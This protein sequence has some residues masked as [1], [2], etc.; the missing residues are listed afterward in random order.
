[1]N[2][3]FLFVMLPVFIIATELRGAGASETMDSL[4]GK[5]KLLEIA[6]D[7][8]SHKVT[9]KSTEYFELEFKGNK[10]TASFIHNATEEGTYKVGPEEKPRA[11]D[12]M[13]TTSDDKGKT[14]LGIFELK[15]NKLKLCVA[16][17][18]VTKR[19]TKFESKGEEII[20]Y[21]LERVKG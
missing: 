12:F 21:I 15:E 4:Q 3:R 10:V 7:G 8:K 13:P 9:P 2:R 1:M 17:P 6:K 18:E 11:I 20:V 5:W 16:E 19:P 14:M